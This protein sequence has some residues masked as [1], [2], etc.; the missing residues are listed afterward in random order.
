MG[1][2]RYTCRERGTK[3]DAKETLINIP[4]ESDSILITA[5]RWPPAVDIMSRGPPGP[6]TDL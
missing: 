3:M 1:V 4:S 2:R 6:S 5:A